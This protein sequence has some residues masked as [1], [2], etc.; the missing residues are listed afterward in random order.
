V[1]QSQIKGCWEDNV[2]V[3]VTRSGYRPLLAEE[4]GFSKELRWSN[5][6]ISFQGFSI[7]GER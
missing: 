7:L 1:C 2:D 3:K 5:I 6:E 4:A